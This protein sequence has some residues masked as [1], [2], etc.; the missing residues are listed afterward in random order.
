MKSFPILWNDRLGI[1][2]HI[3]NR[4]ICYPQEETVLSHPLSKDGRWKKNVIEQFKY[5]RDN[6]YTFLFPFSLFSSQA[7]TWNSFNDVFIFFAVCTIFNSNGHRSRAF[8]E[9]QSRPT[10]GGN[11][12]KIRWVY[13]CMLA[14]IY[15]NKLSIISDFSHLYKNTH[16]QKK[17]SI[18]SRLFSQLKRIW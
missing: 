12:Q 2:W 9:E 8:Y 7:E 5:Q 1:I 4:I 18:I 15:L 6:I 11:R 13:S 16:N 3:N 10:A 14:S 17:H